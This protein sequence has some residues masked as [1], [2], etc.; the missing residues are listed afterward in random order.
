MGDQNADHWRAI[1]TNLR[2]TSFSR[3]RSSTMAHIV[4]VTM[5]ARART[6]IAHAGDPEFDT[7]FNNFSQVTCG[8]TTSSRRSLG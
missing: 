3:I 6:D 5:A 1:P 4:R 2:L 8:P 7:D